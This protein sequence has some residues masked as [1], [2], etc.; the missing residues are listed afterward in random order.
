MVTV[1]NDGGMNAVNVALVAARTKWGGVSPT[2]I[3]PASVPMLAPNSQ[4]TFTLLFP[5]QTAGTMLT[6]FGSDTGR[7]FGGMTRVTP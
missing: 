6:L 5:P 4:T 2:S 7:N 3:S 1:E